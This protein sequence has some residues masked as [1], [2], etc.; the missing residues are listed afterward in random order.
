MATT[1]FSPI[2]LRGLT[3]ANR[4]VVSP[5]CQYSATEGSAADWH[6]MHLGKFA[7]SG[8]GLV[9]VE[10]THV[11][12]RGRITH[13][14]LG[15]YSDNNEKELGRVVDFCRRA[16]GAKLGIQLSH[17][18]RKGSARLPWVGRGE[19]LPPDEQPWRTV[20]PSAISHDR[21]WPV[22]YALD[23][24]GLQV[25]KQAHVDATQ[26]A[27]RL[28]FDLAEV[29]IAHGYLL[30]E[31]LSP[32]SNTRADR[33]GGS[34]ENR[35]RYP[36][37]V[38]AAMRAEWPSD[39]P[40]G[41]RHSVT[42]WVDGGWTQNDADAFALALKELGCD[43]LTASSGG[44]SVKQKIP[45]GEGHQVEFATRLRQTTGLPTMAVGMIFDP[46]HANRIIRNGDA[47]FVALARGVLS[48]P[49]WAWR[50]AASLQADVTFPPQYL[51]G[52]RSGWL[53]EQRAQTGDRS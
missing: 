25:V 15:L 35:M 43:Y 53:R 3:L 46:H 12:A 42:D 1:L 13:G 21:D 27:A 44:L 23:E 34:L 6:L 52:Y 4:I 31:F 28:G 26:R 37:E 36:L 17:S 16:G 5:M 10:A 48:D 41:V 40:M 18:G 9:I 49:H 47:D 39:R 50:A 22:P 24:A 19:S 51:R 14:C 38:F 7:V 20:A 45:I 33:Y 2:T 29:H 11:E 32:L 8:V 30:H